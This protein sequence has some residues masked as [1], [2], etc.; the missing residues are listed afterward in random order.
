M[1]KIKLGNKWVGDGY[2]CYTVAE[3]GGLYK[4][5]EE[6]KR[7][8]DSAIEIEIDAIKLQT[9]EAETMTTKTNF[10]DM[11]ATGKIS[12]YDLFKKLQIPKE[13]QLKIV[14]YANDH[15]ITIFSAPSH[16]KDLELMRE[17]Q[18]PIYKIGAD[19]ACHIPL[20]KEVAKFG[21][22]IIL[23]T[24]MCNLD[25]VRNSVNAIL[26][27][28]NEQLILLHC[29]SDYPAKLEEANLNAIQTM[30][31]EFD[32]PVGFSDHTPGILTTLAA[33]IMG[34]NI[35]ERH[36][37]H[38]ENSSA[39]DDIHS[40]TKIEFKDLITSIRNVEKA[41]GT[42]QKV[43][44]TSEQKNLLSNRVSIVALQNIPRGEIITTESIDIRR[45]GIGI[46]P[47]HFENVLGKRAKID[48]ISE[49]PIT[50]DL[51]E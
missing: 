37:R 30:K 13:L 31:T 44:S 38:I 27:T 35:I 33:V 16:M 22:P 34:A 43:P 20:L 18:L 39:P 15:N 11:E 5:F 25:E 42:G 19:L 7:L 46:Q 6:A 1:K 9:F 51:I 32:L 48:I 36:F 2:S 10:F 17:M 40:L 41:R 28:G 23:S 12:Q 26:S 24:G 3:I 47:I 21:K 50:W 8:I 45:P 4:N 29:V 49:Q 14:K